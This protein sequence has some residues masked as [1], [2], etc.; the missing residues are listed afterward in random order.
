MGRTQKNNLAPNPPERKHNVKQ[1]QPRQRHKR[2][3][4]TLQRVGSL[5]NVVTGGGKGKG[6]CGDE[7]IGVEGEDENDGSRALVTFDALQTHKSPRA[8]RS[9]WFDTP[10]DAEEEDRDE[11]ID[12]IIRNRIARNNNTNNDD[13]CL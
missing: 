1:E 11:E 3:P 10:S 12:D 2:K 9:R 7:D 13:T 4:S 8:S 5:V 6:D